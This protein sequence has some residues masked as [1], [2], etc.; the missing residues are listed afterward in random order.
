M[1]DYGR[2]QQ[3]TVDYSRLQQTTAGLPNQTSTVLMV[4]LLTV[5]WRPLGKE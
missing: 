2:L 3:T 4:F 5:F 1:A